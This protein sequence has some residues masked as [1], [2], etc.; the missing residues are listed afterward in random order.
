LIHPRIGLHALLALAASSAVA[1]QA[2][3]PKLP[4]PPLVTIEEAATAPQESQVAGGQPGGQTAGAVE[5]NAAAVASGEEATLL[6]RS[7][8]VVGQTVHGI[9]QGF[10]LCAAASCQPPSFASAMLLGA[11]A[12]FGVSVLGTWG[13]ITGG[14]ATAIN[15]G[16]LWG[17]VEGFWILGLQ[18]EGSPGAVPGVLAATTLAGTGLG[19]AA[20]LLLHPAGGQ[21][22]L[23]NSG[24]I[25][26]SLL[27]FLVVWPWASDFAPQTLPAIELLA[28]NAGIAGLAFLSTRVEISRGRMLLIDAAGLLGLVLGY[29]AYQVAGLAPS[30]TYL[31]PMMAAGAVAGLAAGA[32]LTYRMDARA[33]VKV[34]L[35]PGGPQG[36][37]GAS[38]FAAF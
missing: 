34:T 15:S 26:T 18:A 12:G 11:G 29:T 6:A 16:T 1:Q 35:I 7:E 27:A 22:A 3:G 2:S 30:L 19:V 17:V 25:W 4:E 32:A 14:P 8:L 13:G 21:V 20:A 5:G 31:G 28:M 24:G 23:A 38:V 9:A 10:L 36:T 33:P 37:P